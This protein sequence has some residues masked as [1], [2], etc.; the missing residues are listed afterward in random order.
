MTVLMRAIPQ[1]RN[2]DV[3]GVAVQQSDLPM[4][5]F[6]H[7]GELKHELAINRFRGSVFPS[8]FL[9]KEAAESSCIA[10]AI[11]GEKEFQQHPPNPRFLPLMAARSIV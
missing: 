1:L 11:F 10:T 8:I 5:Q 6:I 3:V 9:S 4:I 2:G 7:N